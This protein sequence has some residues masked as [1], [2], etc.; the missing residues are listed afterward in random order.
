MID[1]QQ[2]IEY[3]ELYKP[4]AKK[5]KPDWK[6]APTIEKLNEDIRNSEPDF[7]EHCS[8]VIKW[9]ELRDGVLK[10]KPGKGRSKVSPKLIRKMSEW[11]YSSL[12]EPF[13]AS[14]DMFDVDP[15]TYNDKLESVEHAKI[16]NKQ[17]RE[18]INRTEFIDEYVRTAVD[19][20]LV[21]VRVG[22]EYE[23]V[24]EEVEVP[25][26]EMVAITQDPAEMNQIR[27]AV[28]SGQMKPEEA[29]TQVATGRMVLEQQV[30][31]LKNNPT[32]DVIN[33]GDILLD[34]NSR[35][36]LDDARFVAYQFKSSYSQLK[37]M[38]K[39]ENLDSIIIGDSSN[40]LGFSDDEIDDSV[41]FTD[42][43][44]KEFWVTEYWGDWDIHKDGTTTP[45]VA[46][47]VGKTMIGLEENPFPD[48][49]PP[50]VMVAY[51]P[52]RNTT[53]PGEPDAVL[54]EDNQDVIG[55]VTRG[56]IDLMA[57]SANS[58]Q[59][60]SA[61]ALDPAQKLRF[62][63]GKDF[64]FN[65]GIDPSKA[66]HMATYPEIPR[67]AM[68][69]LQLQNNDAESLIG[70]KSF[71][72]GI[73]GQAL[74]STATGVRSAMDAASKRELGILRRLSQGIV[75]IGKKIAAMNAV[76]L[77]DEE[78]LKITDEQQV[79][80]SRDPLTND[81]NL[82]ISVSTPEK[83]NEKAQDLAFMLQTIGNNMD[84]SMQQLILAEIATLKEMPVLAKKIIDFQPKPD[85]VQEQIKQLQVALLEA[86]V[87]NEQAKGFENLADVTEK[88][89]QAELNAAKAETERAKVRSLHSNADLEDLKFIQEQDG[90]KH[91]QDLEKEATKHAL[92]KDAK[93]QDFE[94]EL[95][96]KAM[97][98]L[99]DSE[100]PKGEAIGSDF[101]PDGMSQYPSQNV[102]V[103][104]MPAENLGQQVN[105]LGL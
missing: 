69:M 96:K 77:E 46:T 87:K 5:L 36:N 30:K 11:R 43:A 25:E 45:I 2:D 1:K 19:E 22:W 83:D 9:L 34:A 91:K 8:N 31:V 102:P 47:F 93:N 92:N 95:G 72:E 20:G 97:D 52:K 17:F 86:Q 48:G 39:Y 90:T 101:Q 28:Q 85:P 88:K 41:N 84:Q 67:S 21:F 18:D 33:Y 32:V 57:K 82:K 89:T 3:E 13:L 64:I 38:D 100:N 98:T 23:E 73:S 60:I 59:G 6:N 27:M 66:F 99:L 55:A 15:A 76:N 63:Q 74:G 71:S 58:Q 40:Y 42:K 24:T 26:M 53:Y 62:E 105:D 61:D 80:I 70:K 94:N 14:G 44:R 103:I 56:M 16:L 29:M 75:E 7:G 51:L 68:E 50:F 49:K 81:F 65:P 79:Y 10:E 35:G 12:S 104:D 54:I 4:K 78:I 37:A